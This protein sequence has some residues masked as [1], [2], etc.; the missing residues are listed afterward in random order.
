MPRTYNNLWLEIVSWTNLHAAYLEARKGKRYTAGVLNYAERLEE[1]LTNLQNHLIW[2][3]WQPGEFRSFWVYEPKKRMIHAPCFA[4]RVAHHAFYRVVSPL[5][6]NK[7]INHSYACRKNKGTL[8]ASNA[9]ILMMRKARS[10]WGSVYALKCDISRYFPSVDHNKLIG[11][12]ERTIRDKDTLWLCER[13]IRESGFEEKGMPIG[14]LTSQLFAN[15][16]LD[17]LDHYVKDEMGRSLYVRYMDDFIVLGSNKSSLR[18]DLA[19]INDYLNE[20]L[21]LGLNPKTAIVPASQGVY[22]TGYRHWTTHRLPRKINV[23]RAKKRF[24]RIS[25]LYSI[26]KISLDRVRSIVMSFLGYM[27]Y[28]EGYRTTVSTLNRLALVRK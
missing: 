24:A 5:F 4:D 18:S 27:K 10:M 22:F 16:Y 19:R 28:C 3:T 25:R 11:I 2:K 15:I 12:L 8:A 17:S 7:F 1:N 23:K 6:E 14:S 20:N 13:V 21:G 26:G 9:L